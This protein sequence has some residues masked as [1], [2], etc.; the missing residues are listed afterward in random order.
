[1]QP[2]VVDVIATAA[3][4]VAAVVAAV[5]AYAAM[6]SA[7]SSTKQVGLM[8]EELEKRERPY[9]Y[10]HFQGSR[11]A[12]IH[13]ILEN[14]G[15]AAAINVKARFEEPAPT[16]FDGASLNMATLFNNTIAFFPPGESY[17]VS[18]DLGKHV[19]AE[20]KPTEFKLGLSYETPG[21]RRFSESIALDIGYL[22][23]VLVPPP[24]AADVLEQLKRPLDRIS[25]VMEWWRNEQWSAG[26]MGL[27]GD[28]DGEEDDG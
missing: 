12:I 7:R 15:S 5:S 20:G 4:V 11:G 16:K 18:V 21:G 28:E 24:T 10:G 2:E 6:V 22:G 19:F 26:A 1:M 25:S 9:I 23:S 3:T 17:A 8:I 13:F 27:G 14:K